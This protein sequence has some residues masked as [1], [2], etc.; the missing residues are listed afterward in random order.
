MLLS[1]ERKLVNILL[2]CIRIS[3]TLLAF[4]WFTVCIH[5]YSELLIRCFSLCST[6][7]TASRDR[8]ISVP[9]WKVTFP[10]YNNTGTNY[11]QE[12]E[13]LLW[14]THKHFHHEY[15]TENTIKMDYPKLVCIQG[16]IST[17]QKGFK[18]TSLT[19]ASKGSVWLYQRGML[20]ILKSKH[21]RKLTESDPTLGIWVSLKKM[22]HNGTRID[23]CF[24]LEGRVWIGSA[25]ILILHSQDGEIHRAKRKTQTNKVYFHKEEKVAES[26]SYKNEGLS[27]YIFHGENIS[28][29]VHFHCSN[30]PALYPGNALSL[31][32]SRNRLFLTCGWDVTNCS[33]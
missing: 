6:Y 4:I 8:T 29:P 23:F 1:E 27:M 10:V 3:F 13:V 9:L 31:C 24:E 28:P 21:T 12:L 7:S 26:L 17:N 2:V 16:T 30:S 22:L 32:P 15:L 18:W 20:H 11:T 19:C 14:Q 33:T 25:N 5:P